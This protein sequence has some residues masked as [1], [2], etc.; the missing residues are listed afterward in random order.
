[1]QKGANRH[2]VVG[3]TGI[4][5]PA[6]RAAVLLSTRGTWKRPLKT[7]LRTLANI[8]RGWNRKII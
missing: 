5:M 4:L 1:M 6:Q 2:I 8:R 7:S 3:K